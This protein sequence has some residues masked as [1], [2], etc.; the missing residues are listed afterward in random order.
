MVVVKVLLA[1]TVSVTVPVGGVDGVVVGGNAAG[2]GLDDAGGPAI[3]AEPGR[4]PET[5]SVV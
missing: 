1:L 4:K 2:G 5:V 3:D